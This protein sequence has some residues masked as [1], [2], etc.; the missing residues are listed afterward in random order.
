[1]K[2]TPVIVKWATS[3]KWSLGSGASSGAGYGFTVMTF[4]DGTVSKESFNVLSTSVL[5]L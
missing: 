2:S 4:V 1:V 3:L 5:E